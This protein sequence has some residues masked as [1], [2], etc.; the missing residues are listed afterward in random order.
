M[1]DKKEIYSFAVKYHSLYVNPQTTERDVE[2]GFADQCFSFGFE[3]DCGNRFIETFSSNAFYK[4]EVLDKVIDDIDDIQLLGSAIFSQWRYVTHWADYSNLLD[5]E[6][7]PWFITA[8]GRLA[9][10]TEGTNASTFI[11]EGILQK[12]Q[13]VSNNICYG[14]CPEPDDEVEQ[15]LTITADGRVWFSRYCF[16]ALGCEHEQIEKLDYTI[17]KDAANEIMAS[18]SSFFGD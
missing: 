16:G 10:L 1:T 5:E 14:P 7:R 8:F 15:H 4:N 2:E 11:F 17:P 9:V 6:H 12:I 3:M 18:V 13:L